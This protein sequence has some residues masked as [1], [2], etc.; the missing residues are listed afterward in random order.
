MADTLIT[1]KTVMD[2]FLLLVRILC[3]VNK[4]VYIIAP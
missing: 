1:R 4:K 2:L 3:F